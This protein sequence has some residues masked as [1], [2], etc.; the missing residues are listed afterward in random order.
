VIK[1]RI[2][3]DIGTGRCKFY[4]FHTGLFVKN[5]WSITRE[6]RLLQN[7]GNISITPSADFLEGRSFHPEEAAIAHAWLAHVSNTFSVESAEFDI[8]ASI[9][10]GI[11]NVAFDTMTTV[12]GLD[13]KVKVVGSP[14]YSLTFRSECLYNLSQVID[15]A[16]EK[17]SD[18]R[19]G[20][21]A[22]INNQFY[23]RYNAGLHFEKYQN[24]DDLQS[25]DRAIKPFLGFA[26]LEEST[27]LRASYEYFI[28]ENAQNTNTVEL[29]LLF[30]MGPHKAHQF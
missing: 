30:S 25:I 4:Y 19:Y 9:T 27:V 29:Q 22:Y 12:L 26:V 7:K 15:D 20:F 5:F 13:A 11:N 16:G 2:W 17:S 23:T 3:L 28:S 14:V 18:D 6:I 8:G 24:P 1:V 21:Y 10:Q